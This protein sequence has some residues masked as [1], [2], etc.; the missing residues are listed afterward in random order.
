MHDTLKLGVGGYYAISIDCDCLPPILS[1][2]LV[3]MHFEPSKLCCA[4]RMWF[5]A[6]RN[7]YGA[8]CWPGG[9]DSEM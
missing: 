7:N 9:S 8:E 4:R 1:R 3:I 5:D 6:R 2:K